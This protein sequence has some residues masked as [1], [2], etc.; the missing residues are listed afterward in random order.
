MALT[1]SKPQACACSVAKQA[2][3][4]HT[5]LTHKKEP[6]TF[7]FR[8]L[9]AMLSG[10]QHTQFREESPDLFAQVARVEIR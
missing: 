4:C 10:L 2:E 3:N 6:S 5:Y 8:P 1:L 7:P 9:I